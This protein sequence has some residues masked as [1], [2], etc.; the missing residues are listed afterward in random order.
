DQHI[1]SPLELLGSHCHTLLSQLLP[2]APP[3][4]IVHQVHC[5]ILVQCPAFIKAQ[6]GILNHAVR[7]G[8]H[9]EG[10]SL[11]DVDFPEPAGEAEGCYQPWVAPE[12]TFDAVGQVFESGLEYLPVDVE[13]EFNFDAG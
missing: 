10:H 2:W 4:C 6:Y 7:R 5:L 8:G 9:P 1:A 12:H 3:Q 11:V 13:D